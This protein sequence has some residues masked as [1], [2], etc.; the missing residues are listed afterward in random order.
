MKINDKI[1]THCLQGFVSYIK[2]Y[3]VNSY[4]SGVQ[5][6]QMSHLRFF[7]NSYMDRL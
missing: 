7:I 3:F 4:K 5:L 6:T 1:K 2:I